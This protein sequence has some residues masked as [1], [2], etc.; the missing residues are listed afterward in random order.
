MCFFLGGSH[1]VAQTFFDDWAKDIISIR[2]G[3]FLFFRKLDNEI[4]FFDGIVIWVIRRLRLINVI[5]LVFI[6]IP[7][8]VLLAILIAQSAQTGEMT[9]KGF[10][11]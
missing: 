3:Y 2:F 1:A 7:Q 5:D 6:K 9:V 4:K 11:I 10:F 8:F